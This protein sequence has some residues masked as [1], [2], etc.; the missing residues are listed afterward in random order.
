MAHNPVIFASF[1]FK[2]RSLRETW[3]L[4]RIHGERW[5]AKNEYFRRKVR[6]MTRL[7]EEGKK[8]KL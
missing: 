8:W 4:Y 5:G 3:L 2:R 1:L 7:K 6:L